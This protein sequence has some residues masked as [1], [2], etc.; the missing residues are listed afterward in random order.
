MKKRTIIL[1]LL[2]L[3]LIAAAALFH[4]HNQFLL[5]QG[6]VDAPEVIVTSKAKGRVIERHI[7]RGDDVKKGQLLL[8][9]ESPELQAQ[10]AAL[11]AAKDQAQ[12]Q[13]DQSLHGTREETLRDLQA[14]LAQAN[15]QYQNA[16]REFTRLNN[17][18]GKGYVSI[19][20]LDNA[21]KAKEV[22]FQQVQSAKARLEEG[23]NGDRIE[24]RQQYEAAVNQAQQ[25]LAE[26]QVQ[27]DDLQV[28]APVDGEVGPIPAE[29]GELFNA[30]SPLLSLISLPQSYF[31]YN[32]REDILVGVKKGNKV[33]LVIPA[34]GDK[35]VEAEVRYIAPKGDYATKRATRATGD[36]DLKT[37]EVRLYPLEPIDGLRPGM[38]VLWR[39]DK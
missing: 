16:S 17:L 6:E 33:Q 9:L 23:K 36:F 30:G 7:E 14:S 20:E 32:L 27:I 19:N 29:I 13:L 3:I 12:A 31:V 28:K 8:T 21:R 15:S 26:I 11:K 25:K 1:I 34:L 4:S 38:S 10:Y 24:L 35:T 2:M 18:L 22:A 37:F 39:W 5:L